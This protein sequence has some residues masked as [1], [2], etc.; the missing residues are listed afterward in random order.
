[1]HVVDLAGDRQSEPPVAP[2]H[3][4][5]VARDMDRAVAEPRRIAELHERLVRSFLRREEA[6]EVARRRDAESLVVVADAGHEALAG[7]V[8]GDGGIGEIDDVV[9]DG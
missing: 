6:P 9:A 1:M 5:E 3:A 7:M 4:R 8:P 2:G